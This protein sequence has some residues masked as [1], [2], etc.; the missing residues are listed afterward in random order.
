MLFKIGR[1]RNK[2]L[3]SPAEEDGL[4]YSASLSASVF[5]FAQ[6][7]LSDYK[8][9]SNK[10]LFGAFKDPNAGFEGRLEPAQSHESGKQTK[11]TWITCK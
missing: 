10:D 8:G 1:Q 4:I 2:I 11:M 9:G 6:L 7:L 3:S 5:L